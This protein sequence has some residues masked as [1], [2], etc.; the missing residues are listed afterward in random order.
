[1]SD[2][3]SAHFLRTSS[4]SMHVRYSRCITGGGQEHETAREQRVLHLGVL[5]T[6][7]HLSQRRLQE[8]SADYSRVAPSSS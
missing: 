1:M 8:L 7:L 4:V 3:R 6:V 2:L 5:H